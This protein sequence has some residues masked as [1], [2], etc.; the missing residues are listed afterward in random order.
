MITSASGL[1]SDGSRLLHQILDIM[2][3]DSHECN[4]GSHRSEKPHPVRQ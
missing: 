4:L 1:K 2:I 3:R